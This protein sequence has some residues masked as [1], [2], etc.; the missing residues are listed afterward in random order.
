M[1]VFVAVFGCRGDVGFKGPLL[2]V[3]GSV[4]G[5][6]IATL[7]RLVREKVRPAAPCH[8][9]SAKEFAQRA[10]IGPNSAFLRLLGEFFRANRYCTGLGYDA[11]HFRV[12]AMGFCAMRSPLAA[13]RR[14]VGGLDGVIPPI[15]GGEA[16]L[17]G[18]N[19]PISHV[20]LP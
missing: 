2:G 5:F 20:I 19:R 7:S 4:V 1:G 13:C 9:E 18:V 8:R 11:V 14:R 12:A 16:A 15:G 3:S 10:Q 17:L 6:N